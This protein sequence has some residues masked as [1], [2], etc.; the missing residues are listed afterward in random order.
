MGILNVT[1]DSFFDGGRHSSDKN[2]LTHAE[3][4]L[5]DGATFI[6]IGGYSTRPGAPEV[7]ADEEVR[8]VLPAFNM[9]MKEFPSA[10]LSIDTFRSSTA[11]A[12]VHAGASMIND[13]SG[14]ELDAEMF[15]TV[16][17]LKI[18][19][20]LMHMR[21]TPQT[22]T[23]QTNYQN[24]I[25]EIQDY[26]HRKIHALTLAGVKD[27]IVD[28]GFGFAKTR[29]QNFQVLDNLTVF[30]QLGRPIL[31]G[32]SRKSMIWKTLDLSADD[33]LNGTTSLNTAALHNGASILRVHDVKEAR[34]VVE[35]F[36]AMK[37][38]QPNN[39]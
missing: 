29:E 26:F 34:Q 20:V 1:P 21:G 13:V 11:P 36:C 8:R 17:R 30:Q 37:N 7:P 24:L 33:A 28:P 31:A 27:I 23:S 12:A 25:K 5:R 39:G 10:R 38:L 4:M 6:D 35:L 14:G 9:I 19:Y 3:T 22:M 2:I 32:L 16:A 15:T 18:P